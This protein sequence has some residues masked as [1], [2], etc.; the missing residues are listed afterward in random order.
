MDRLIRAYAHLSMN[1]L[2]TIAISFASKHIVAKLSLTPPS[3]TSIPKSIYDGLWVITAI[4]QGAEVGNERHLDNW[5]LWFSLKDTVLNDADCA[6]IIK[7]WCAEIPEEIN[8]EDF[9]EHLGPLYLLRYIAAEFPALTQTPPES[10]LDTHRDRE[11][12]NSGALAS[13][14]LWRVSQKTNDHL[15]NGRHIA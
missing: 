6:G 2:N 9:M 14:A 12:N 3:F 5:K 8:Q 10:E 11:P 13:S 15:A 7:N 1:Y 4:I